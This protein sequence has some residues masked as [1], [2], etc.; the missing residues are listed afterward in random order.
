MA[1][2]VALEQPGGLTAAL[3][4]GESSR[5]VVL[6]CCVVLAAVEDDRVQGAVELAV[7]AAAE[8]VP[9]GLAARGRHRRDAG[10][11]GE[12]RLGAQPAAVRPGDDHLRGDDRADP[13]LVQ[14]RGRECAYMG[15]DLRFQFGRFAACCI[16]S[17]SEAA[18]D[19]P[20]RELVRRLRARAAEAATAPEQ[21]SGR[22][23]AQLLSLDEQRSRDDPR[24]DPRGSP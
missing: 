6:G 12:G 11:S 1:G 15:E 20:G 18:Q 19:E 7:A 22:E 14:Q 24:R 21:P 8:P 2:E 4:F 5:D 16:D 13:R 9:G 10:E 3:A 23:S 17:A